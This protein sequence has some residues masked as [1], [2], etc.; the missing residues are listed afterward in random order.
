[1][2]KISRKLIGFAITLIITASVIPAIIFNSKAAVVDSWDYYRTSDGFVYRKYDYNYDNIK[3]GVDIVKYMGNDKNVV[4]PEY[5][6][7]GTV[8]CIGDECFAF[9]EKNE[10]ESDY[11]KNLLSNPNIKEIETIVLP[12]SIVEIDDRAFMN[13]ES[14]TSV[15]IPLNIGQ[16][17][18]CIFENC[19]NLKEITL[20]VNDYW[21]QGYSSIE[22]M[23]MYAFKGSSIE[24]VT[25]SGDITYIGSYFLHKTNITEWTIPSTVT[26]IDRKAFVNGNIDTLIFEED[27]P[28]LKDKD[29]SYLNKNKSD[30]NLNLIKEVRFRKLPDNFPYWNEYSVKYDS[31]TGYWILNTTDNSLTRKKSGQVDCGDYSWLFVVR[32]GKAII[33]GYEG[34]DKSI[35]IP[36]TVYYG[37]E[38][39]E[40]VPVV[41]IGDEAF[42]SNSTVTWV[43]IPDTVKEIGASA[44][45]GCKNLYDI[46]IPDSVTRIG[47]ECFKDCI[48]LFELRLPD[49]VNEIDSYAFMNCRGIKR[50]VMPTQIDRMGIGVFQSCYSLKEINWPSSMK[51]IPPY[52]FSY[53]KNLSDFSFFTN[54]EAIGDK[55]F[56]ACSALSISDFGNNIKS[57]GSYAFSPDITLMYKTKIL[58]NDFSENLEYIGTGAFKWCSF[59][60]GITIPKNVNYMGENIFA[61]TKAKFADIQ[62]EVEELPSGLFFACS[63][64]EVNIP[65]SVKYIGSKAFHNCP[66]LQ[67]VVLGNNV[68]YIGD[69]AFS[70]CNFL[71]FT[72]PE[73]VKYL[74]DYILEKSKVETLY[75]NAVSATKLEEFY[76]YPIFTSDKLKKVILGDKVEDVP[77]EFLRECTS[78]EEIVFS[79]NVK[80]IG[81]NAFY[82]CSSLQKAVFPAS[83]SCI[84]Q[85]AFGA[86]TSLTEITL[87]DSLEILPGNAFSGCTGIKVINYNALHCNIKSTKKTDVDGLYYS[88]FYD[89]TALEEIN[90]CEGIKELPEFFFCGLANVHSV[91]IPSTVTDIGVGAFA[92]SGIT[93]FTA[94]PK[95]ESIEEYAFYGC[96]SLTEIDLGSHV[97]IIGESAFG[98][99]ETLEEIYIPDSVTIL[100]I[101]A[102]KDCSCLTT[103]RMSSNVDYIPREAFYNCKNLAYFTW[104]AN[105]KLIGRLAFGNCVSLNNFDFVNVVKIYAN[106]FLGS[107]ISVVQLGES[108]ENSPA[109][110][111][112]IEVQSF[113]SCNNLQML[114]V[115]GDVT[116]IKNQ[117]FADCTNLEIAVISDSVSSIAEDAFDG[118]DKLTIYCSETSYAYSYAQ[119]QGIPVSTFVIAPIPNQTYTGFA[120]KPDV[121]V[122]CS[123]DT[124]TKNIDYSVTYSD[125]INVGNALV[126]VKGKGDFRMFTSKA[127][128]SIITRNIDSITIDKIE[129]QLYTGEAVTPKV[130]VSYNGKMLNEGTDYTVTY[131][132]NKGVGT[133]KAVVKGAGNYSGTKTVEFNIVETK[134]DDSFLSRI[135]DFF[136]NILQ[137]AIQLSRTLIDMFR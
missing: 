71:S 86:C 56:Y 93:C 125:N 41:A 17:G 103:V 128:F 87:P 14:L 38:D 33:T 130:Y 99:C 26:E 126:T 135:A 21:D 42:K 92:L 90:L 61:N 73:S 3:T 119:A 62:A 39:E 24:S 43:V 101:G 20:P 132:S 78:L 118:C 54:A 44:F 94:S 137:V 123:G 95:L 115:G 70:N 67:E 106:S 53:C 10:G 23:D 66:N 83:L 129:D 134:E 50:A 19:K 31:E 79:D 34:D 81:E 136:R 16:V 55:A 1:M 32:D 109:P 74:G 116:T 22:Y 9:D 114:G 25:I 46:T 51:Y 69:R 65:A 104:D 127:I 28:L 124:L 27:S 7:D 76:R 2:K 85:M 102:F 98:K 75:Y 40:I 45:S 77:E 29:F 111:K 47:A 68:E 110:L 63:I 18:E 64:A 120:I 48:S 12:D 30:T 131:S 88:P 112:T 100:E 105:S 107:G 59:P 89:L 8:L 122:T 37:T 80:S 97:M 91:N 52:T 117:A 121:S 133:A 82:G 6:D 36:S 113:K 84:S 35:T 57:I 58:D 5:I 15:N 96:N 60:N 108:E 49:S 72:I 11:K 13:C 4:V